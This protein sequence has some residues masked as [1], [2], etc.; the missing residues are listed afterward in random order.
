MRSETLILGLAILVGSAGCADLDEEIVT[1]VTGEFF[2]TPEGADAA[3]TGT[4]ARLRNW[5][6]QQRETT[7]LMSGTDTWD[8]GGEAGND[9]P[10]NDYTSALAPI[11]NITM[12]RDQ[13]Q[14]LYEAVNAANTAI[15]FIGESTEIPEENKSVRLG[16]AHFLRAMFYFTLVRTWGDVHLT[17]EP[18]EGVVIEASRTPIAQIYGEAIIPDLEIAI[19]NLPLTQPRHQRR[20]ADVACGGLPDAC[21]RG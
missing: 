20:R 16:E 14:N 19:A 18:T 1:G 21:G 13:W 10:F 6:G 3:I 15:K 2:G 17:L 8:K 11:M 7:M 12:L 5:Y 9:A 4:Y